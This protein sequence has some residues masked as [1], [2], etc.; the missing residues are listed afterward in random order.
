M[1][2]LQR[3]FYQDPYNHRKTWEV[4][5]LAGSGFYL[6]QYIN[7]IQFGKGARATKRFIN[8]IGIFGF[9]EVAHE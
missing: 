3:T 2:T 1:S 9:Q 5:R 4:V 6:R 7:G 8:D